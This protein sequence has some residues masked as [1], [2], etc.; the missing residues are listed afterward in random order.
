MKYNQMERTMNI[1]EELK[2]ENLS[3]PIEE[4]DHAEAK[5]ALKVVKA[6]IKKLEKAITKYQNQIAAAELKEKVAAAK[7]AKA[8]ADKP[9]VKA[10]NKGDGNLKPTATIK[11]GNTPVAKKTTAPVSAKMTTKKVK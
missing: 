1:V 8:T 4:M 3:K 2:L 5:A 6:N 9:V 11:T 7:P 10:S